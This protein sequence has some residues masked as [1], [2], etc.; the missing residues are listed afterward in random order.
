MLALQL[1]EIALLV[2]IVVLLHRPAV[3]AVSAKLA[4]TSLPIAMPSTSQARVLMLCGPDGAVQHEVSTSAAQLGETFPRDYE[5]GGTIY[6]LVVADET[7]AQYR[8]VAGP[9]ARR[10]VTRGR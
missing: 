4:L 5:Y 7:A 10:A 2:W 9:D 6:R 3:A 8:A 1:V